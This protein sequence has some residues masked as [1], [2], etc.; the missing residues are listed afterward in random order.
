M[1]N[2]EITSIFD[3]MT[4]DNKDKENDFHV[5]TNKFEYLNIQKNSK[6][7][8]PEH[9]YNLPKN[10]IDFSKTK[11]TNNSDFYIKKNKI[12]TQSKKCL[13]KKSK[14]IKQKKNKNLKEKYYQFIKKINQ[15]FNTKNKKNFTI[16]MK[17][18][19]KLW[20]IEKIINDYD[21]DNEKN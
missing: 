21:A 11:S 17:V 18:V 14:N 10:E 4:L 20:L 7:D 19:S 8:L 9:K 16:K 5:L 2:L 12:Q 1:N 3:D 13:K 6:I 15:K